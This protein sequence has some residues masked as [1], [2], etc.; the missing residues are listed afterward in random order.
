[1][2][3]QTLFAVIA[4]FAGCSF[5][6]KAPGDFVLDRDAPRVEI[7]TPARGTI[8]GD[9][10]HVLVTGTATDDSGVVASVSV[11][12][13]LATLGADGAWSADVM[14]KPGTSLLLAIATDAEGN[15]GVRTRAVV[16]GP[17]VALEGHV[18]AGIR[19]TLSAPALLAICHE[20]A[21]FI[22]AGGLMTTAQAINPIVDAGGGPDCLYAQA[23]ITSLTVA[24][25]DVLMGPTNGG[26][27][28]S[29]VLDDVRI[30]MHLQWSVSC[31][32]GSRDIEVSADRVT[33]QGLLAVGVADRKLDIRFEGATAQVTGFDPQLANVPDAIIDMLQLDAAI[34][35]VFASMT[36]RL[37][38]P[39][40][41]RELAAFDE[42]KPLD[43]GG[44]RVDIDVEPTQIAFTPEGG[45][46]TFDT[47]LRAQ[48]DGGMFVFVPNV[49]PALELTHGFELAIADDTAN[50][51]L[52]SMWSAKA[53]D[54][55]VALDGELGEVYDSVDLEL[56]VPPH[57]DATT[58][59]LELTIGDWIAT[60]KRDG[61]AE[62]TVAIHAKA[63][64][65]VVEDEE[66]KLHINVGT[67]TLQ[68]DFVGNGDWIT[69][70]QFDLIKAF[71]TEHVRAVG[72]AAVGAIPL[73]I[74]GNAMPDLW[75][76]PSSGSMLVA[77]SV[78]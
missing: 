73:P 20:T 5:P 38:V 35:P 60:F 53:F 69:R 39:M 6:D 52:T 51:L 14:V 11:N 62:A 67:P 24:D 75:V 27:R 45:T 9:V 26:I 55:A 10:T 43:V 72:S 66:R 21:S 57:V 44:T 34:S 32:D 22:E 30:G 64:L 48:G 4:A 15:Q 28:V 42:T 59:P 7:E 70:A 46:V 74:V 33:V 13:V 68:I 2:K 47:S 50:Q 76:E 61:V 3:P 41:A 56:M 54:A 65:Y 1:M 25:A 29:A 16:A 17:M 49:A 63:A 31:L 78:E 58:R 19:G 71:A 23:S 8:A 18:E 37:V 36:E 40:A 77:G 12:G